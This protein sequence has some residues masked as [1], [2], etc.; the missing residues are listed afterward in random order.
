MK[1]ESAVHGSVPARRGRTDDP[2]LNADLLA[3][4]G[5]TPERPTHSRGIDTGFRIR[6]ELG[7]V[8]SLSN[9]RA[10]PRSSRGPEYDHWFI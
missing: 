3:A 10:V 2:S 4:A 7:L 5:G 6:Q 8:V 9:E 1:S